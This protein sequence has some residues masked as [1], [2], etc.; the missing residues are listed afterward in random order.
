MAARSRARFW[1]HKEVER[2]NLSAALMY[3]W[4]HAVGGLIKCLVSRCISS[5]TALPLVAESLNRGEVLTFE[6]QCVALGAHAE[7]HEGKCRNRTARRRFS[8]ASDGTAT[9]RTKVT[10]RTD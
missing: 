5:S 2:L 1:I 7:R 10:Q 9:A 6:M 4:R 3:E 8:A